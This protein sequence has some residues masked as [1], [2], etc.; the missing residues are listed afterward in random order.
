MEEYRLQNLEQVLH[1]APVVFLVNTILSEAIKQGVSDIHFEPYEKKYRIRY[2]Q[3]GIL[4]EVAAPPLTLSSQITARIKVMSDL[5]IAEKRIPQDGSFKMEMSKTRSIDF[6]VSTCPTAHGEKVVV[7]ILETKAVQLNIDTLGL[8]ALQKT[9]FLQAIERPQGMILVTGPTG[10][11]KTVTLYTALSLLNTKKIN[12][13]TIEDPV[14]MKIPGMNQV[15][16][17]PKVG[18]T[19]SKALPSFLRQDP[20]VIMVGEIRDVETADI[21]IKAAQTGHLVFSTLHTNSAIETLTRLLNMGISRANLATSVS[22]IVAQQL[23]RTL[24]IHCKTKRDDLDLGSWVP[25]GFPQ[26]ELA[27]I[28]LYKAVGCTQC[29][30]GYKGRIGLFEVLPITNTLAQLIMSKSNSLELFKLAQLEGMSTLFQSGIEKIK[31]GITSIEEI[32]RIVSC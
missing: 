6:R 26:S 4:H 20:D 24:C 29:K 23:A 18:L 19:F 2:R 3:D 8:N 5:D 32:H 15:S 14:E 1:E 12:I 22:M 27:K 17:N 9:L 21:A 16:I 25:F 28:P 10:S 30:E 11:G 7:R 31:Q 13:L